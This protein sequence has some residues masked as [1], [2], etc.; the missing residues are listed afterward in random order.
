MVLASR[1]KD[2]GNL[3]CMTLPLGA[4]GLNPITGLILCA[5]GWTR[6]GDACQLCAP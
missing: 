6:V 1:P 3:Y 2:N 4:T 5:A